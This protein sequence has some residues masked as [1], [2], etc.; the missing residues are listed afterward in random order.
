MMTAQRLL[1]Y[2]PWCLIEASLIG[3]GI[4]YDSTSYNVTTPAKHSWNK[5]RSVFVVDAEFAL[6]PVQML[7]FWDHSTHQWVK[8]H[9]KDRLHEVG[10]FSSM[11]KSSICV[12]AVALLHGFYPMYIWNGIILACFLELS[13]E[14][15]RSRA[16]FAAIPELLVPKMANYLTLM[17]MNYIGASFSQM[18]LR[19]GWK[20]GA[21]NNHFIHIL[22]PT[23]LLVWKVLGISK[24]V[25]KTGLDKG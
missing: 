6:S 3:C 25:R 17:G 22:I 24:M 10:E 4:A 11:M 23:L 13:K 12:M 8:A 9:V 5:V 19:K 15:Y 18:T 21:A 14:I 16:A 1:Y 20:F 2:V 7:S